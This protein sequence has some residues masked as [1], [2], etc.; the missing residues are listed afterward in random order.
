MPVI[1]TNP[2]SPGRRHA[3]YLDTSKLSKTK[4]FKKLTVK[5]KKISGRNNTGKIT[6][7]HRGGAQKRHLRVID[8]KRD[9]A[10]IPGKVISIEYDPNR[11]ANIA[12][13]T[14]ADGEKRYILSPDELRVGFTVIS[15]NKVDIQPGNALPM[16]NIPVGTPIHNIELKPQK[17]GQ[18]VR[19][20]GNAALIQ[21]KEGK[22][23]TVLM[24]S[25]EIRL[26]PLDCYATI[27]QVS[28]PEWKTIKLG[29]AGRK[30]H[31]GWRP[32]VRGTAQHP[33][34]HPHGGGEG[35]SGIGMPSPKSPWG[36]R[37]LGK[38]TRRPKKYSDK[39]IIKTKRRRAK[40]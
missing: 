28:N 4:P 31:R 10:D 32:T 2:T 20:A 9:K 40:K 35:R 8:F 26:I 1:K 27:G 36:K 22:H 15:G 37:T 24:P 17:G 38:K 30:R 18:L 21:S 3:S 13:V 25:K 5:K 11:S 19:S 39:L 6:V 34:S 29:K 7:R 12:L 33:G 23:A 14:Y 16:K